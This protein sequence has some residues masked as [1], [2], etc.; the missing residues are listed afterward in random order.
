MIPVVVSIFQWNKGTRMVK[1][2]KFKTSSGSVLF[3]MK[4]S[5]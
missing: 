2:V 5:Y 4:L 1:N 3:Q